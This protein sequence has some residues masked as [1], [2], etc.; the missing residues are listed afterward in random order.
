MSRRLTLLALAFGAAMPLGLPAAAQEAFTT[1]IEPRPFYGATVTIESGVRVFRPLPTTRQVIINPGGQT[2]LSLGYNDT[3]VIE[4][5]TSTNYNYNSYDGARGTAGGFGGRFYGG[6]AF[7]QRFHD[8]PHKPG[9][10]NGPM[11]R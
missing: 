8:Q 7:P 9:G 10:Y 1:R 4:Q 3:R 6:N 11:H 5:S 2:P